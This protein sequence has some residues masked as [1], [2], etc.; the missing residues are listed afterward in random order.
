MIDNLSQQRQAFQSTLPV[1]GGTLDA[2][3]TQAEKGISIHPP[4]VGR[5]PRQWEDFKDLV[6]FQSTLPVWGGTTNSICS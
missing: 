2:L 3:R 4:R 6:E 5:D 1:W